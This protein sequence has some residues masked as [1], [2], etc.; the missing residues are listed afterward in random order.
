MQVRVVAKAAGKGALPIIFLA[1]AVAG[2]V[3]AVA[4][5][6]LAMSGLLR[7][8]REALVKEGHRRL[9][10]DALMWGGW[11]KEALKVACKVGIARGKWQ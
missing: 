2:G 1:D 3:A 10:V 8:P 4:Q 9:E 11:V 7:D 6:S 5:F